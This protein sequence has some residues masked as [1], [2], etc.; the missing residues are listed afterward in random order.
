MI[1]QSDAV[2]LFPQGHA[3]GSAFCNREKERA[4]LKTSFLNNEHTVI[5]APRRYGKSSLIR[6]VLMETMLPGKRLDLLPATNVSFVHK[7]IKS[8]FSELINEIY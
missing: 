6:Q 8:C 5:V 1:E 7:A 3:I 2:H 4:R